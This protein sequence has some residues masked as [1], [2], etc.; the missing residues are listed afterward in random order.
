MNVKVQSVRF[1]ADQKLLDYVEKKVGKLSQMADNILSAE[2][3]LRLDNSDKKENKI[4]EISLDVPKITNLFAKN[5]CETFEEAVD[6]SV[7]ALKKQLA[8]AKDKQRG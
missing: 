7:D 6:L 2:V 4:A 5:Q 8:K 3:I 1:D